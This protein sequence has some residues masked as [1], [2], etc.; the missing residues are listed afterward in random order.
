MYLRKKYSFVK[1]I[2]IKNVCLIID[3]DFDVS[4]ANES[5]EMLT[6]Y[7]LQCQSNRINFKTM[8]EK[9][10]VYENYALWNEDYYSN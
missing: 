6:F 2:S 7:L 1:Y 3:P 5:K 9:S 8:S 10:E 4:S